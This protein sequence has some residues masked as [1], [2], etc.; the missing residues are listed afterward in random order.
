MQILSLYSTDQVYQTFSFITELQNISSLTL[1]EHLQLA[2]VLIIL[3][4]DLIGRWYR[5][6]GSILV[7]SVFLKYVFEKLVGTY[8]D[9]ILTLP[10]SVLHN[11]A[12]FGST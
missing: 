7:S 11:Q 6:N 3:D 8:E 2:L 1:I 5:S 10:D 4:N 12:S 9:D